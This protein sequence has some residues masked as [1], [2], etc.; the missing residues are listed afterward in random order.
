MFLQ[1]ENT[2]FDI[3]SHDNFPLKMG[4]LIKRQGE[5]S[6]AQYL[7][8]LLT[9]T[10]LILRPKC[11]HQLNTIVVSKSLLPTV[12]NEVLLVKLETL[13]KDQRK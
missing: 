5:S 7:T 9:S 8:L 3:K 6:P 2:N 1:S 13:R 12:V 11:F 10:D 4:V